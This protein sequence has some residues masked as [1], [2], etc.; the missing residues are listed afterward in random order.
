MS[1]QL[2]RKIG[3]PAPADIDPRDRFVNPA[4]AIQKER[5]AGKA[6]GRVIEL[7]VSGELLEP[8]AAYAELDRG[9]MPRRAG[10]V[11]L[12]HGVVGAIDLQAAEVGVNNLELIPQPKEAVDPESKIV[13]AAG[14]LSFSCVNPLTGEVYSIEAIAE[15]LNPDL[16]PWRADELGVNSR[17]HQNACGFVIARF[18][19]LAMPFLPTHPSID[20]Q[21]GR[22]YIPRS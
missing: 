10:L 3:D 18:D 4:I 15:V 22:A 9:R 16:D 11:E 8:S 20:L 12:G 2:P 7:A 19:R 14:I 1:L 6:G 5:A 13:C 21:T 17:Y